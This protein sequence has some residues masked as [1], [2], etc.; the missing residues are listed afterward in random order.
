M[1]M[2]V[3]G[4]LDQASW[5]RKDFK[6]RGI[7]GNLRQKGRIS[8]VSLTYQIN[9]FRTAG[10]N[11]NE[12]VGGVLKAISPNLCLRNV[13]EGLSSR[14][15]QPVTINGS[16]LWWNDIPF[17]FVVLKCLKVIVPSKQPD[18]ITYD[19]N[20]VQQFFLKTLE[21]G[22]ASSYALSELSHI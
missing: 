7:I 17:F 1:K 9:D 22:I 10:Y 3:G 4:Y 5:L 6:I 2:I 14:F 18:D 21:G 13:L 15:V 8:F 19:P 20:L 12:V 11:N 16:A